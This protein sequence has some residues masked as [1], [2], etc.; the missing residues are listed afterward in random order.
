MTFINCL[1]SGEEYNVGAVFSQKATLNVNVCKFIDNCGKEG[2]SITSY[3][4]DVIVKN[5]TFISNSENIVRGQIYIY[6]AALTVSDSIFLNTTSKY[7]TAIFA[8]EK[9]EILINNTKFINLFANKTA[10]A[11]VAKT[12]VGLTVDNCEFYNVSST[13]N[14]GAIFV[15]VR[16]E[17]GKDE[18]EVEI[19]R[20]SFDNCHSAFG[21]AV[22]QLGGTLVVR[23]STFTS[24]VADYEGGAIYTSFAQVGVADSKFRNNSLLDNVSYGGACY[25]DY[26]YA[27]LARNI[28]ENNTGFIVS[29][30]C[31]YDTD[32]KLRSNY[33]DN[34]SNVTSIY[35]VYGSIEYKTN[36]NTFNNDTYSFGNTNYF[37]NFENTANPFIILN[38]TISY[39]EM[40]AKFDLRE[41]GWVFT[42]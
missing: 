27:N 12:N 30:V 1:G 36:K 41:Y 4:S 42:C 37:Y 9:S 5:S 31:A 6:E 13:N 19:I 39:D 8:E 15:D 28:F 23:N 10:G 34:P 35:T 18:G 3:S 40:P 14:G 11:I 16:G 24:N 17:T 25:F 38:N 21:G 20:T 22:L 33:F 32:L 29:T 26:G 2:S 7:A